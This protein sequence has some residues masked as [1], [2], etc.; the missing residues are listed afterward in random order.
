MINGP[1]KDDPNQGTKP[2][3]SKP[4]RAW[5]LIPLAAVVVVLGLVSKLVTA[6][7]LTLIFGIAYLAIGVIHFL[8]HRSASARIPN[9][10]P[11]PI[12]L[13]VASHAFFVFGFLLQIDGGDGSDFMTITYLVSGD[14]GLPSWWPETLLMNGLVFVPLVVTWVFMRGRYFSLRD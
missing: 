11:A 4:K 2:P 5:M 12:A 3:G 1:G 8:L 13:L 10:K 9:A 14:Y 7:W 6:G